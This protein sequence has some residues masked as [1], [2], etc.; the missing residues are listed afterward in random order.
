MIEHPE[1]V[2]GSHIWRHILAER[3]IL[4]PQQIDKA[5]VCDVQD[6]RVEDGF[7]I[8]EVSDTE[9]YMFEVEEVS[10]AR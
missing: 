9:E 4:C 6:V 7:A 10:D 8:I 5:I 2:I 1:Q 3:G